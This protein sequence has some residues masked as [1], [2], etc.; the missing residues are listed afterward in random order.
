MCVCVCVGGGG[1][2]VL[3]GFWGCC[4]FVVVF[5]L[6]GRVVFVLCVYICVLGFLHK[7]KI[8]K[9]KN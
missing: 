4:F 7:K 5:F 2:T 9:T 8:I 3:L 1:V 6:G